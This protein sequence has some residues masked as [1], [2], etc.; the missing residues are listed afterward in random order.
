[1]AEVHDVFKLFDNDGDDSV[2]ISDIATVLRSLGYE[3]PAKALKDFADEAKKLDEFDT[4]KVKY[5]VFLTFVEKSKEYANLSAQDASKELDGMR[6]GI[7]HFFEGV[8]LKKL[9]EGENKTIPIKTVKHL[10]SHCGEKMAEEELDEL[11]KDVNMK[12]KVEDGRVDFQDF[13]KMLLASS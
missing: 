4:G 1:M 12:C 10:L 2:K 13:K 6:D 11:I 5:D 3:P 9:R 8:S 7:L